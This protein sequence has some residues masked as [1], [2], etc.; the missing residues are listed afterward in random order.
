MEAQLSKL[1]SCDA[2]ANV[3]ILLLSTVTVEGTLCARQASNLPLAPKLIHL[4]TA[5]LAQLAATVTT[6]L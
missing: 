3:L 5:F 4:T 6:E 2:L 1:V